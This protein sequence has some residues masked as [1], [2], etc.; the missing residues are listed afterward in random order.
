MDTIENINYGNSDMSS[1]WHR[2][3][4]CKNYKFAVTQ[5][6]SPVRA[7]YFCPSRPAGGESAIR[8]TIFSNQFCI[9]LE[10]DDKD[11]FI[12]AAGAAYRKPRTNTV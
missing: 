3:I 7:T 6:Q 12:Q 4:D 10:R 8:C 11:S 2:P 5:D 1:H 9:T